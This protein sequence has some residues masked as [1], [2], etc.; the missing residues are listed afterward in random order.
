MSELLARALRRRRLVVAACSVLIAVGVSVAVAG[1]GDTI[2]TPPV[3]D[4]SLLSAAGEHLFPVYWVG[5]AFEG[6]P[7]TGVTRDDGGA[8]TINY[9]TCRQ[10]GQYNC[11]PPLMIVTTPDN[12]FLPAH[13]PDT[14]RELIRGRNAAIASDGATVEIA[15]GHVVID[16]YANNAALARQATIAMSPINLPGDP[17]VT[18]PSPESDTGYERQPPQGPPVRYIPEG[19]TTNGGGLAEEVIGGGL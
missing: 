3:T 1:C 8:F 12:S 4:R 17:I 5:R 18:L 19:G 2:Q 9:G 7:V 15:T 6:M 14:T 13:P 10:G 16:V 11:T